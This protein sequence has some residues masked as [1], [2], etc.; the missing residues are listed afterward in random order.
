MVIRLMATLKITDEERQAATYLEWSDEAIG[1]A[2][3][4]VAEILRDGSGEMAM[5]STGAAVFLI[6]VA[7]DVG[8]GISEFTIQGAHQG[9]KQFGD[10]KITVERID[11]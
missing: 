8:A 5:K 9:V 4:Q 7:Y 11:G 2:C 6:A 3:K 1:K 10:W